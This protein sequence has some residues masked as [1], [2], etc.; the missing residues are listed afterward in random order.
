MHLDLNKWIFN[1]F[2]CKKRLEIVKIKCLG[3]NTFKSHLVYFLVQRGRK[4]ENEGVYFQQQTLRLSL[5]LF[6]SPF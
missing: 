1:L 4:S 6:L 5:S 3:F 2:E